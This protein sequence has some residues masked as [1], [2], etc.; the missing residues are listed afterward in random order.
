MRSIRSIAILLSV[1]FFCSI[2]SA[3]TYELV[4]GDTINKVDVLGKRQGKW[5]ITGK[6]K[7]LPGYGAQSKIEEGT[8]KSSRKTGNWISYYSNGKVKNE[9]TYKSGR[10]YGPYKTYY[11]NGVLEEE[12]N[13]QN[14]RNTG[15]FKR[16]HEN[17]KVSQAFSFNSTGKREGKQSYYYENGQ[18]MIEGDWAGGKESGTLTE[19]YENGELKAKKVFADGNLDEARTQVYKA[20]TPEPD[21]VKEE[22][23]DAPIRNVVATKDEKPNTGHFDGNGHHKLYNKDKILVKD[24]VF[25]NY[26]LIDGKWYKYDENNILLNIERIKNGRYV[27]DVP[28]DEE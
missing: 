26:K 6:T 20:K 17:G 21:K 9:I 7:R 18:V 28:F 5:I 4:N 24:G 22:E 15:T 27:G 25:R 16:Y 13:W 10:P 12:G 11:P 23:K 1:L 19:Y 8:Y 3:Q 2:G 14:N